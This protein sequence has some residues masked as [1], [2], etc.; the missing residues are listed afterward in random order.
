MTTVTSLA[1]SPDGRWLV[2]GSWDGTARLWQAA[3]GR[4]VHTF[5][6]HT[7]PVKAV[8]INPQASLVA[9]GGWD[10]SIKIWDVVT[11]RQAQDL[12][13]HSWW[14]SALRFNPRGDL[15]ASASRDGSVRLWD[16]STGG[17]VAVIAGLR[18]DNVVEANEQ[19]R[20]RQGDVLGVKQQLEYLE[21]AQLG[22]REA[23]TEL[24]KRRQEFEKAQ[25]L[26]AQ[27]R[28]SQQARDEAE[29]ALTAAQAAHEKARKR[30]EYWETNYRGMEKMEWD[31]PKATARLRLA[32][33][34]LG[35]AL[36]SPDW[37]VVTPDGLF[38]GTA[39]AAQKLIAW[40]FPGD[41]TAPPEVFYNE[42]YYPGL[43]AEIL[44]GK[45]PKAPRDFAQIDRRQPEIKLSL[46]A[47]DASAKSV[48]LRTI[49]VRVEVAEASTDKLHPQGSGA[50][51]VRLF[52]NG[53]LVKVWRGDVLQGQ[54]KATLDAVVPIVLGE[55]RFTAYAFNGDNIKSSDA[56]LVVTGAESLRRKGTAYILAVG[57]N[58]YAN[59]DYNLSYA[60]A[61]AQAFAAEMARQQTQ[62]GQYEKVGVIPILDQDATRANIL[63]A[64]K[65]LAGETD[66]TA[67]ST[68]AAAVPPPARTTQRPRPGVALTR[69]TPRVSASPAQAKA[70]LDLSKLQ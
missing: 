62:L 13:G 70:I 50:R 59:K 27:R 12:A 17:L 5:A 43:L 47:Q 57:I 52:R 51:D 63:T 54:G 28:V 38:D 6:G 68:S 48:A 30:Q 31:L 3:S 20:H 24:A 22:L 4:L 60:V 29:T 66:A 46:P 18:P 26:F 41:D 42:F 32:R 14:I 35:R 33:E 69:P 39:Q 34:Q 9:S 67:P 61:D 7:D 40:R 58:Q 49:A 15:L 1:F 64:L 19:V 37:I 65:R 55:N 11:G 36:A 10:T 44:A 2:S 56:E 25:A 45:R 53:L 21:D 8:A 16:P 23:E